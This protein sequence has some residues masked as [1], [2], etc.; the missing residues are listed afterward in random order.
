[1]QDDPVSTALFNS[2]IKRIAELRATDL[3][4]LGVARN[5]M[6]EWKRTH[7]DLQRKMDGWQAGSITKTDVDNLS[8][9]LETVDRNLGDRCGRIERLV[10]MGVG[11]AIALEFVIGVV[12]AVYKK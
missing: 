12:L 5:E 11:I 8:A 1:M 4:A 7:N 2:E 10:Y 6:N 9:R 3:E